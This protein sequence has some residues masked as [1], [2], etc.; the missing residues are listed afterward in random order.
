[1]KAVRNM[2]RADGGGIGE[3]LLE[4]KKNTRGQGKKK[5]L[6]KNVSALHCTGGARKS[7]YCTDRGGIS[8]FLSETKGLLHRYRHLVLQ[9]LV[10]LVRREV[11]TVEA[12]VRLRQS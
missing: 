3:R 7:T 9:G 11:E 2:C 1:V 5:K 10:G 6:Q 4:A 12:G 8:L